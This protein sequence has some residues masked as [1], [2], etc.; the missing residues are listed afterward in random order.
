M[1]VLE[2]ANNVYF[3]SFLRAIL[4]TAYNQIEDLND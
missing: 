3:Y 2:L 1:Y 4:N